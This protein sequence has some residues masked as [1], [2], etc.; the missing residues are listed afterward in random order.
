MSLPRKL[1]GEKPERL[2]S[3]SSK[4]KFEVVVEAGL[5]SSLTFYVATLPSPAET[6]YV[7]A[8]RRIAH[9]DPR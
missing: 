1:D 3:Y 2:R 5:A 8:S 9:R 7:A 6:C 4:L